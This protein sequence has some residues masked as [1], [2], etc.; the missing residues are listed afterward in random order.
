M[1]PAFNWTVAL[2]LG[3]L[4]SFFIGE[5][6]A[7]EVPLGVRAG[8]GL[9][10]GVALGAVI[11][12]NHRDQTRAFDAARRGDRDECLALLQKRRAG[13]TTGQMDT[14]GTAALEVAVGDLAAA[15]ER[16]T[17]GVV[18]I[19]VAGRLHAVV[20]AHLALVSG[21]LTQHGQALASL[22]AV[23]R[24]PHESVER[25]RAYLVARAALS[26][27]Q[28][29]LLTGADH[30]LAAYQDPEARAYLQWLRAHH[31]ITPFDAHDRREDMRR[32]IELATRHAL[33][34]LSAKVSERALALERAE[35]QIGPYRR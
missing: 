34:A 13:G 16:L 26:P 2:V 21:D 24:L 15:R 14:F 12:R 33:P 28:S 27:L 18:K 20:D 17:R 31:E 30:K 8:I 5:Y 11:S 23:G 4:L 19:S 22:L 10:M 9:F 35:A 1:R 6:R 3:Q 25:Y 7:H 32:A 29:S